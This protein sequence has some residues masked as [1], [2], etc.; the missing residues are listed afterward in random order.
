M[1][2]TNN[3]IELNDNDAVR[4]NRLEVPAAGKYRHFVFEDCQSVIFYKE[5]APDSQPDLIVQKPSN[6]PTGNIVV[7]PGVR[8]IVNGGRMREIPI[9][10]GTSAPPPSSVSGYEGNYSL[11]G[12]SGKYTPAV[13]AQDNASTV[14]QSTVYPHDSASNVGVYNHA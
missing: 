6:N 13:H 9:S 11:S 14:S 2:N 1:W 12:S 7:P 10:A 5:K 3:P 4:T 8:L